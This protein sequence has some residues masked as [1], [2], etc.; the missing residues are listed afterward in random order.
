MPVFPE[1]ASRSVRSRVNPAP[2]AALSIHKAAR[3]FTLPPGLNP[4]SF[5]NSW[6]RRGRWGAIRRRGRSGVCPIRSA[7]CSPFRVGRCARMADRA[8]PAFEPDL[9]DPLGPIDLQAER[10]LVPA[11]RIRVLGLEARARQRALVPRM[12]VVVQDLLLVHLARRGHQANTSWTLRIPAI[13][14]ST[15][16]VSL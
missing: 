13:R 8:S 14:A 4:S 1:V 15:S 16:S 10:D 2:S 3:S 12:L 7:R 6:T 11:Q 9:G 5:A